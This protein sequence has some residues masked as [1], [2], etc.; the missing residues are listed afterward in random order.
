M[1]WLAFCLVVMCLIE[2]R[3]L[4]N[5]ADAFWFNIFSLSKSQRIALY[6]DLETC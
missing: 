2:R 1:W 5:I 6:G 4:E 3:K